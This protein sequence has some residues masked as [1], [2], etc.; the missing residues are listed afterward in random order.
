MDTLKDLLTTKFNFDT[1]EI[2]IPLKRWQTSF[3]KAVADFSYAFDS[4]KN[5]RWIIGGACR[6]ELETSNMGRNLSVVD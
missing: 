1:H 6:N 2:K 5:G 3:A 4:F